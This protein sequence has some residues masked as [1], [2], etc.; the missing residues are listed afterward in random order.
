LIVI[1]TGYDPNGEKLRDFCAEINHI[2]KISQIFGSSNVLTN[3]QGK[4]V[5]KQYTQLEIYVKASIEDWISLL[6]LF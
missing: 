4:K 6:H 5:N 3:H 1:K 2:D